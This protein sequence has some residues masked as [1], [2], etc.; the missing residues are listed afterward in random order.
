MLPIEPIMSQRTMR[1]GMIGARADDPVVPERP[2]RA[3]RRPH[4]RVTRGGGAR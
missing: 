3:L 1:A 4:P 2:R